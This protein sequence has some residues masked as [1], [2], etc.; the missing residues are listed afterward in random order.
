MIVTRSHSRRLAAGSLAACAALALSACGNNKTT[1][2]TT[3]SGT[4]SAAAPTYCA[5]GSLSAQGSTFQLNAEAQWIKDYQAKCSG[6]QIVYTGTG[7]GAGKTAFGDGT[8]DFGGTDTLPKAVEQT[9]ADKRCGTGNKGIITPI[10]AGAV[11]VTYHLNGVTG[12]TFSP[13]TLAGIFEKKIVRW[14][15]PAIA[16]DNPGVTLPNIPI[17][18]LHRNDSSGTTQI[19]TTWLDTNAG[20]AW[21]LGDGQTVNWPSDEQSGKG[22]T[23]VTTAVAQ[24]LGGITYTEL[25]FAAQHN[26]PSAKVKNAAGQAVAATGASV[27]AALASATVDT[28]HGDLRVSPDFTTNAPAAYPLS[29]PTFVLTCNA[30]N[31]NAALL[32]G[33]LTYALTDGEA[34]LPSLGYAPLPAALQAKAL[35][36]VATLT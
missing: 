7:S 22:S 20:A 36:Q 17:V 1:A 2:A 32:K 27:S 29:S 4:G 34:V 35:A 26:L 3:S 18:P 24:S 28:S 14:N 21:T 33:Y 13:A 16:A 6:A 12:L 10:V 31:K 5:T 23:G 30:G 19:F 11:V 25:S 8:A 15:D 9:A